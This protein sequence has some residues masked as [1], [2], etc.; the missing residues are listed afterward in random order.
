MSYDDDDGDTYKCITRLMRRDRLDELE[1]YKKSFRC[2]RVRW[3]KVYL[4]MR[5]SISV[6]LITNVWGK[7]LKGFVLQLEVHEV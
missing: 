1:L 3:E 6:G 2:R 4:R 5:N 7:L